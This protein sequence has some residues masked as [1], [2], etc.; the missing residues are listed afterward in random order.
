MKPTRTI[1]LLLCLNGLIETVFAGPLGLGP[2]DFPSSL[3]DARSM[4]AD[5]YAMD[6]AGERLAFS[7]DATQLVLT[8][9]YASVTSMPRHRH[10]LSLGEWRVAER[11]EAEFTRFSPSG[12][13]QQVT[14]SLNA[15]PDIRRHEILLPLA[16]RVEFIGL[17]VNT[18]TTLCRPV[19]SAA[20]RVVAYG[21]SITQGFF[22]SRP[23]RAYP[24]LL[25]QATGWDILNLGFCGRKTTPRDALAIASL[26]P[27]GILVLMGANDAIFDTG[28]EEFR[29]RYQA[30]LVALARNCPGIPIWAG[31][32]TPV[33]GRKFTAPRLEE[34]RQAIRE[35]TAAM[36][37]GVHLL[38]GAEL[39]VAQPDLLTDGVHPNDAGFSFLAR[40]L[41]PLL[42]HTLQSPP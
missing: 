12:G 32:P 25:A 20:F 23:S 34:Y 40:T 39:L 15:S 30:F 41:A 19:P 26:K 33:T 42:R 21:D 36:G 1:I 4:V 22:A 10:F 2:E 38:E 6:S 5:P 3:G 24:A 37:P 11:T 18:E 16:D 7:T 27:N 17:S 28:L 29:N 35:V 31:T 8:V 13:V 9:R 14:L